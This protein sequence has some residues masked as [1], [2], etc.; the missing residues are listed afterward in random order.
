MRERYDRAGYDDSSLRHGRHTRGLI[1]SRPSSHHTTHVMRITALA[2]TLLVPATLA[3]QRGKYAPFLAELPGSPRAASLADAF[4]AVRDVESIFYNPA[5]LA[6]GR[7]ALTASGGRYGTSASIGTMAATLPFGQNSGVGF[8]I[9]LLDYETSA[10][11]DYPIARSLIT[12]HGPIAAGSVV[13]AV[14]A[15]R[16]FK[17]I[18]FGIAGKY[19]DDRVGTTQDAVYAADAGAAKDIGPITVGLAVQNLGGRLNLGGVRADLPERVTAGAAGGSVPVGPFD[20]SAT[21]AVSVRRD[22]HV[23]PALGGELGWSPLDGV[24]G[25]VRAGV[26]SVERDAES[27]YTL[28]AGFSLDRFTVDYSFEDFHGAGAVHRVGLRVR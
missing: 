5:M 26:R 28:G 27:P 2:V 16:I 21:A 19:L 14:G 22:G 7:N 13:A 18:R 17:G 23:T 3:A 20:V 8:G 10:S 15:G 6:G 25:A 12:Q 24:S 9:K 1:P 4:V 11:A